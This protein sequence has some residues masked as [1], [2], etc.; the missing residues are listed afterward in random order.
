MP[1]NRNHVNGF[2][3]KTEIDL[4]VSSLGAD[5]KGLKANDVQRRIER[6]RKLRDKYRDLLKRQ[7]LAT[8]A[9]TG[10]KMGSGNANERTEKK[11]KAFDEALGR[12]EAQAKALANSAKLQAKQ[13]AQ[14]AKKT[15]TKASVKASAKSS[16]KSSGTT[17]SKSS[18]KASTNEAAAPAAT[19]RTAKPRTVPAIEVLR[20][21]LE[22]KKDKEAAVMAAP[23]LRSR[24]APAPAAPLGAADGY[25]ATAAPDLRAI[26]VAGRLDQ[27]GLARIQGH[28]GTQV[29]RGQAKRDSRGGKGG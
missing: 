9:R 20:K 12:F 29:R 11:A 22:V 3:A 10:T 28:I 24:K 7:K 17:T 14:Q 6:T 26:R 23:P 5:L 1:F 15:A 27:S 21:A 8:R 19:K 13:D 2:L 4:F 16:A 25:L 18:A